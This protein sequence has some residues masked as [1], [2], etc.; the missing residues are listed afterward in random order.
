MMVFCILGDARAYQSKSPALFS[1]ILNRVGI[2]GG[3][4]PFKVDPA[5]IGEAVHSLRVLNIA[6]ANVTVPYKEA[7]M[8]YLDVLSEGANIIGSVNTIVRDNDILKGYNT[9][10][11]GFMNALRDA[12]FE[13]SGKSALVFGSGGVAKAVTFILNW[14]RAETILVAGRNE[15]LARETVE[16]I[17][18]RFVSLDSLGDGPLAADIVVNA[19]TASDP[20]EAP[21]LARVV[22]AM[23]LSQ[24]RLILDLNYG[25][26][27]NFWQD[28]AQSLDTPFM[29]GL[30][31][32]AHQA[33]K[34]FALW[35]GV[36]V[37]PKEILDDLKA[38]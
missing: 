27:H 19:T 36:E 7:V 5:R 12:G 31:T 35:T 30:S 18:G 23:S 6:G 10:A 28:K 14:L 20:V 13:P 29:D 2:P 4:V 32:L 22:G 38:H 1:R 34:T 15:E 24:C 25:R 8:P 37:D 3:Y 26:R 9:N 33:A 17:R 21:D 16:R 11:I